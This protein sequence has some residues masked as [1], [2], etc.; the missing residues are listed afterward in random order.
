MKLFDTFDQIYLG[1]FIGLALY[2]LVLRFERYVEAARRKIEDI[3][4]IIGVL[5]LFVL[6]W[7]GAID[8]D[9]SNL[10][11]RTVYTQGLE[12]VMNPPYIIEGNFLM[13]MFIIK[14]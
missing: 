13:W 12:F 6:S 7:L 9:F 10:W 2:G 11:N 8:L 1:F 4:K 3:V 5:I 14:K